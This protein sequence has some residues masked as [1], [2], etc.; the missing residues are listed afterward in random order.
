ML[1]Y[2]MEMNVNINEIVEALAASHKLMNEEILEIIEKVL[3]EAW[4][5]VYGPDYKISIKIEDD[6]IFLVREVQ[7]VE[8][9][10]DI[11]TEIK[12]KNVGEVLFEK[13]DLQTLP[14]N[15]IA[16]IY[17]SLSREIKNIHKIR[18]YEAYKDQVGQLFK[19]QVKKIAGRSIIINVANIYEGIIP[20]YLSN[21]TERFMPGDFIQC[22]LTEVSFNPVD[23]QLIFERKSRDFIE[24]LLKEYIP[25]MAADAIIIK[26]IARSP[27]NLC[28]ILVESSGSI[29]AVGACLGMKGKRRNEIIRELNGE[30]VD[31]INYHHNMNQQIKECFKAKKINIIKINATDQETFEVVIPDDKVSEAIGKRGQNIFLTKKLLDK[32]ITVI[33]LT[34]FQA[35]EGVKIAEEAEKLIEFGISKEEGIMIFEKFQNLQDAI[36]DESLDPELVKK[37]QNYANY[38][39]EEERTM[40]IENGGEADFFLSIPNIPSY[41]F[42]NLLEFNIRNVEDLATFDSAEDLQKLTNLDIDICIMV[43]EFVDS[44]NNQK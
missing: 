40:F 8:E 10:H 31:F 21:Q 28:K 14:R 3:I 18:E 19:Y 30:K 34:D 29:N 2:F 4:G 32:Q 22:R 38:L 26:N 20:Y 6:R 11:K 7:V 5:N 42:L 17:D 23:Y 15:I 41:V 44:Q 9:V 1:K 25:E 13:L 12:G 24:L 27:G 33:S 35:R 36:Y 16:S 37:I 43:I 39:I